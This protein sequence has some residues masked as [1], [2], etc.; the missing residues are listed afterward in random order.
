MTRTKAKNVFFN[1][2]LT[3]NSHRMCGIH[4]KCVEFTENAWNSPYSAEFT[5]KRGIHGKDVEFTEMAL[6]SRSSVESAGGVF[7][8]MRGVLKHP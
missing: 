4:R 2:V 7:L 3:L 1:A 8:E 6:N 5:K